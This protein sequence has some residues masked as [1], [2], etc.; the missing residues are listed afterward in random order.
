MCANG[1]VR[2]SK[3]MRT[4]EQIIRYLSLF[5]ILS[6]SISNYQ[7][8]LGNMRSGKAY[9]IVWIFDVVM[10]DDDHLLR[11]LWRCR[12]SDARVAFSILYLL[13]IWANFLSNSS[14]LDSWSSLSS[15][16]FFS[17]FFIVSPKSLI[18]YS[19]RKR[20]RPSRPH[21]RGP[22]SCRRP[23]RS[24]W[25]AGTGRRRWACGTKISSI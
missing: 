16:T 3:P 23:G 7:N 6:I 1:F 19:P 24:A 2:W 14:R 5:H 11:V 18:Y 17:N 25:F 4:I 21:R 12:I 15:S 22:S 8:E 13:M 10:N 9:F 20:C